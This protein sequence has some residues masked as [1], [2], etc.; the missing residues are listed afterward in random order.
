[1]STVFFIIFIALEAAQVVLTFTKARE[2]AAWLKTR[3]MVR[4]AETLALIGIVVIPSTHMKWRFA[5]ALIVL[6]IRLLI[7][8]IA[9]LAGRKKAAGVKNKV[10]AVLGCIL[11]LVIVTLSLAPAFICNSNT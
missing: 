10:I 11:S 5:V 8:G 2:K 6:I 7:A 1:M 4:L 9:W 3:A